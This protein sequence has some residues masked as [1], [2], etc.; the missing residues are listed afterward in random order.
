M[1]LE[2]KVALVTGAGSGIGRATSVLFAA[3]GA[4]GVASDLVW[5][6]SARVDWNPYPFLGVF[7]G[8][9]VLDYDF[10]EASGS[11]TIRYDVRLSG[12]LLGLVVRF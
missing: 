4:K 2:N 8:Y 5:S 1:R 9:S 6:L 7:A 12:P 11:D 3:E 10:D